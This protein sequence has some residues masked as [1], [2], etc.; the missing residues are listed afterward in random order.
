MVLSASTT[1]G[2]IAMKFGSD[3][4]VS[5]RM[6]CKNMDDPF[7]SS[8]IVRPKY[9]VSYTLVYDQIPAKLFPP[10]SAV[11]CVKC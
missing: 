6:N 1:I 11:L 7:L 5:L 4:H 8:A 10:A 9:N 2:W 3:I